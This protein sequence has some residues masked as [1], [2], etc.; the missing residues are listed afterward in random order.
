MLVSVLEAKSILW[1]GDAKQVILP[2]ED[3]ELCIM[4]F[5][6]PLFCSL[7]SGFIKIRESATSPEK[8]ILVKCGIA[9]VNTDELTVLAQTYPPNV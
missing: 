7:C 9:K 1:Q 4:D 6:Q 3:G 2:S 8:Q 5:H